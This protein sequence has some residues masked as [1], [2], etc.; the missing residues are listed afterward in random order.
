M[1]ESVVEMRLHEGVGEAGGMCLKWVS[2]GY[3]GVPDRIVL[4][5]DEV[6]IFVETKAPDG[7]LESWQE[8]C[9]RRLRALGFRVEVLWTIGD[10]E[11][12][13]CSL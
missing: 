3:G 2:P 12:F 6:V 9:H 7:V 4:M 5:P 10:V 8:R 13:L 1:R 11:G